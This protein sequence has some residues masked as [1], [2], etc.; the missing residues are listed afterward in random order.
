MR[1]EAVLIKECIYMHA[2]ELEIPPKGYWHPNDPE[3]ADDLGCKDW[4]F[5]GY[6]DNSI[7]IK[8]SPCSTQVIPEDLSGTDTH[9]N[10]HFKETDSISS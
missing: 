9:N 7:E 3:L 8:D 5:T 4:N 2:M 1:I 10:F 6:S